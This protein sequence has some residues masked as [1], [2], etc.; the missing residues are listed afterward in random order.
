MR[1]ERFLWNF[2]WVIVFILS[3]CILFEHAIYPQRREYGALLA[4][5]RELQ[6]EKEQAL[7][8]QD[9]LNRKLN[10]ESDPAWIELSLMKGLGLV[11]EEQT[12]VFFIKP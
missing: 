4:H 9:M 10:S 11:P 5:L 3:C 8:L 6:A 7:T 2:W 1:I 12:K